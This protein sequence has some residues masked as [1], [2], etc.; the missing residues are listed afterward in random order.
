MV[1]ARVSRPFPLR[2]SAALILVAAFTLLAPNL[3]RAATTIGPVPTDPGPEEQTQTI[4]WPEGSLIFTIA[5]PAGQQLSAPESGTITSWQLY[6]GEVTSGAS[7]QLRVLEHLSANEYKV[8]G[9]GPVQPID[10]VSGAEAKKAALHRFEVSVPIATG[11]IVGVSL[12]RHSSIL[13]PALP[14][15]EEEGWEY[16]CLTCET[17]PLADGEAASAN[18]IPHQWVALTAEIGGSAGGGGCVG[19]ACPAPPVLAPAPIVPPVTVPSQI[20][21]KCK[22][23]KRLK[24]GHCVKKHKK[25]HRHHH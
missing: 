24:H 19:T 11:Q 17:G 7:V 23:G 16:G 12:F 9:S 5:G 14:A 2:S 18:P 22:K 1:A 15:V 8:V 21:K 4:S 20:K 13:L 25:K 6:T 10:A 3:A